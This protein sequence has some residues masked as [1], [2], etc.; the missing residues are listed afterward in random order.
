MQKEVHERIKTT[1]KAIAASSGATADVTIDTKTLVTYND[2]ALVKKTF[3]SP[4]KK[5]SK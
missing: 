4:S 3:P 2:P 1:V 5:N